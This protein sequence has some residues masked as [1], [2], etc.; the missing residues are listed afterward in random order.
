[1]RF[2]ETS[3]LGAWLVELEPI[4]DE[5]GHFART[6]DREAWQ[7]HGMDPQVVQCSV[8]FNAREGTLRGMH[9][10][11]EPHGEPK[12]M[13]VS[14]GAIFDVLVDLR[15]D[16][17]TYRDWY[18]VQLSADNGRMLF[19]PRGLAHGF[20]TLADDSEVLYQI[21]SS[22]VPEA[23]I[24]VRWDDPALAIDWPAAPAHGR[25]IGARDL[26]WPLLDS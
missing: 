17:A 3:L 18:G 1:V 11:R 16:S 21:G 24:G 19:A 9:M 13:R 25:T 12:L 10:Q 26:A 2:T 6:F 20:Q 8:S 15:E 22:Y 23:A 4:G 5:R 7:A 14:R